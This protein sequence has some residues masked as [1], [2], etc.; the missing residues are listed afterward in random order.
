MKYVQRL[1]AIAVVFFAL[2]VFVV[3][4]PV[5]SVY[6]FFTGKDLTGWLNK[7]LPAKL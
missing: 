2:L 1:L 6:Y 4:F 5:F 3:G 7:I